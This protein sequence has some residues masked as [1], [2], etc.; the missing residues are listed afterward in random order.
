MDKPPIFRRRFSFC[1][2]LKKTEHTVRMPAIYTH[3]FIA[4]ETLRNLPHETQKLIRPYLSVYFFGAQGADFCF[5][6]R[7]YDTKTMNLGSF[8]HRKGGYDTFKV[9]QSFANEPLLLAYALGYITHY[10]ADG[11]FH[12][13]VYAT[14]GKSPIR[15]SRMENALDVHFQKIFASHYTSTA[16]FRKKL[17]KEEEKALF[18]LYAEIAKQ[19]QFPPLQKSAFSRA[20]SLF[21]AY[22]PL[23]SSFLRGKPTKLLQ[24]V[25]NTEKRVWTYPADP[26]KQK[27][28]SADELFAKSVRF[29]EKLIAEFFNAAQLNASLPPAFFGKNFLTGI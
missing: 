12:P 2:T 17:T 28:D 27:N 29:S 24:T 4:R 13:Y 21:N 20:I 3:H 6:Y 1:N 25:L 18:R 14:T 10:A 22:M 5:F 7:F 23:S 8:L 19:T 26:T 11:T 15:H 9:M 16:Y